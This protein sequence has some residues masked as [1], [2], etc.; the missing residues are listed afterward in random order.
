[1]TTILQARR[2]QTRTLQ[3]LAAALTIVTLSK[4]VAIAVD[5]DW[6]PEVL[7]WGFLLVFTAPF[8]AATVLVRRFPRSGATVLMLTSAVVFTA[9][10]AYVISNGFGPEQVTAAQGHDPN[11]A[12]NFWWDMPVL[13]LGGPLAATAVVLAGRFLLGGFRWPKTA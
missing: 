2:S 8:L 3:V 12:Q 9:V 13:Y 1:M 6:K 11:T 7:P 5:A 4:F 10:I